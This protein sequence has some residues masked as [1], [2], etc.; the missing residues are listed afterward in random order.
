MKFGTIVTLPGS[1]KHFVLVKFFTKRVS[2][3]IEEKKFYALKDHPNVAEEVRSYT[4][5]RASIATMVTEKEL[6]PGEQS[7][8]FNL[9]KSH[10]EV[11][12]N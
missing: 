1:N 3:H 9:K 11:Y 5:A 12:I 4:K 6:S 2:G 7:D 8:L 10:W